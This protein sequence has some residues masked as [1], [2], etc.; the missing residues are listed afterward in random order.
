MKIDDKEFTNIKEKNDKFT[1]ILVEM[2]E[3][4][5]SST[6]VQKYQILTIFVNHMSNKDIESNFMVSE[7]W[8][9]KL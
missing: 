3:K 1:Q 5:K 7:K 4:F 8:L 2:K 9:S 6:R